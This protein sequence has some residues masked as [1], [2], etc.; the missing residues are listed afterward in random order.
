M[1]TLMRM[2]P[3]THLLTDSLTHLLTYSPT[4]SLTHSLTYSLRLMPNVF[5]KQVT[6]RVREVFLGITELLEALLLLSV[7]VQTISG[8]DIRDIQCD[9]LIACVQH[10]LGAVINTTNETLIKLIYLLPTPYL[11]SCHD[12]ASTHSS[13]FDVR[14]ILA[15]FTSDLKSML[16]GHTFHTLCDARDQYTMSMLSAQE[17]MLQS[18]GNFASTYLMDDVIRQDWNSTTTFRHGTKVTHGLMATF[19]AYYQM[20]HSLIDKCMGNSNYYN[21][22]VLPLTLQLLTIIGTIYIE[23]YVAV[24]VGTRVRAWQYATDCKYVLY[25]VYNILTVLL[26]NDLVDCVVPNDWVSSQFA[27]SK[28][29]LEYSASMQGAIPTVSENSKRKYASMNKLNGVD[30]MH[31][32]CTVVIDI[33]IVT[34]VIGEKNGELVAD[35]LS[36]R[37]CDVNIPE[38]INILDLLQLVSGVDSGRVQ[39]M[40]DTK[41]INAI[42]VSPRALN[43]TSSPHISIN[44]LIRNR[45]DM[46]DSSTTE[47]R[48]LPGCERL[49]T[50][51][52]SSY[53]SL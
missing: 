16:S 38:D 29:K 18:M 13:I 14:E 35:S 26:T 32:L 42:H 43:Y 22:V 49:R 6:K 8:K 24:D 34:F 28:E 40:V 1:P 27:Y 9:D 52:S 11:V 48:E 31:E 10:N 41:D 7:V 12:W 20:Y 5:I 47:P 53:E 23:T 25:N 17:S 36:T 3:C 46:V 30:Y 2:Q 44:K 45:C 4:H 21:D 19:M 50:I 51:L 39:F 33:L 37:C 15:S